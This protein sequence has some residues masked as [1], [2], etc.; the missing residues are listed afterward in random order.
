MSDKDTL[1]KKV[2]QVIDSLQGWLNK[3]KKGQIHPERVKQCQ[4]K[5]SELTS[6]LT[7][8][9]EREPITRQEEERL[10]LFPIRRINIWKNYEEQVAKF[11]TYNEVQFVK[12][13]TDWKE[14]LSANGRA[15]IGWN[16]AYFA[17][18]DNYVLAILLIRY[19]AEI[20]LPE[21][22]L[23]LAQQQA[24]EGVHV[25]SYN[26]MI[27]AVVDDEKEKLKLF[28][29]VK[30]NP[31]VSKTIQWLSKYA[32]NPATP[33]HQC[34]VA[35]AFFEGITFAQK[36]ASIFWLRKSQICPGICFANEKIVEDE[37]LHARFFALMAGSCEYKISDSLIYQMCQE[38]VDIECE[39]VDASLPNDLAGMNK[40]WMKQYVKCVADVMLK[41]LGLD[42]VYKV[43]NPFDF[44]DGIGL[45]GKTN[46][47]EKTVS[48]YQLQSKDNTVQS[49]KFVG[50]GKDLDF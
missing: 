2:T 3:A 37:S 39:F 17:N 41:L 31:Y 16:L 40:I 29:A 28:H 12:D 50:L 26:R 24:T 11:W 33:L 38:V 42:A 32:E 36:F 22:L 19:F 10:C 43:S 45:N 25:V 4:I 9:S 14:K 35:Q 23:C 34:F 8:N 13:R 21:A 46:F 1:V 30:N 15:Y 6:I 27:D 20:T 48:E 44:M 47:F 18:A 7:L 5:I 49:T